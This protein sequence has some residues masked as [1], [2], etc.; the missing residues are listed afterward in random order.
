MAESPAGYRDLEGSARS[1]IPGATRSGP[2]DPD[3]RASV[4]VCLR[5]RPGAPP[6]ADLSRPDRR[7]ARLTR[8]E[9]AAVY[10]ADPGDIAAVEAFAA[11][12]GLTVEE[13]SIPRRT[14][15][16]AGTVA[17]LSAAFAVDLRR[18]RAGEVS[19]RGYDGPV[20]LPAS[21][22]PIV[23]GV[24]GLDNR[25]QGRPFLRFA[26][27]TSAPSAQPDSLSFTPVNVANFYDF[28]AGADATGQCI[29]L[30]EI[31][32]GFHRADIRA[33]FTALGQ[34]EPGVVEVSIDGARNSPGDS[35]ADAEPIADIDVAGAV[36]PGARIAVYFAPNNEQ[37]TFDA[38]STA[39]FDAAN[40]PSVLSIS[41]GE[42]EENY[43]KGAMDLISGMFHAAALLGITVLVSSG[44][45]GSGNLVGDHHAHVN[46]PASD[47][48]V[49]ACGGTTLLESGGAIF[50]EDL[51][52]NDIGASGGGISVHF[53]VPAWQSAVAVPVSVNDGH[54]GRGIPDIAGN[55][56]PSRGYSLIRNGQLTDPVGGTSVVA[57]LYAGLVAV[58]NA[59]LNKRVGFLN[60][61][62][63]GL[64]SPGVLRDVTCC[65]DN[66]TE[67][68]PGYPVGVGWDA[69]TGLGSINGRR[70]LAELGR[71]GAAAIVPVIT[72]LLLTA[73]RIS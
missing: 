46:Y 48:F 4:S 53:P 9:F 34:P 68:A 30:L 38:V 67:S 51:W 15:V 32:G 22:I 72:S 13:S 28:P 10:G 49:T 1:P 69:T 45:N 19:Y 61:I 14:V 55:A 25:P 16:L 59:R 3:Q 20:H 71:P 31:G 40:D 11:E 21:L 36:A 56:D 57:P 64:T 7:P 29:G 5:S 37:G 73:P 65:G 18:Y 60:P 70:L 39:I 26:P 62:L 33:W 35:P 50:R 17:Q 41:W 27:A 23:D 63:Y 2:A 42:T 54:H 8:A 52:N 43:S 12:H 44:D 47:P 24:L 6:L 58:M 66:A